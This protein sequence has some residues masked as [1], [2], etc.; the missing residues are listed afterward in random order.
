L[1]ERF[2]RLFDLSIHRACTVAEMCDL[3]WGERGG[4]WLWRCPL[5]AW[6][7][8]QLGECRH[9]LPNILLSTSGY[10]GMIQVVAT[11]WGAYSLL[12]RRNAS[13]EAAVT[14]LLWH[15]QVPLKV[16]VLV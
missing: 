5:M 11:V 13:E 10:G 15:K 12:T 4:A 2:Q 3:G 9:L 6:E 1:G 8:E 14:Y 16:P 7:E